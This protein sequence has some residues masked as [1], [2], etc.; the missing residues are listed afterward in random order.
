MDAQGV[1]VEDVPQARHYRW[2]G[3]GTLAYWGPGGGGLFDVES[4]RTRQVAGIDKTTSAVFPDRDDGH[5]WVTTSQGESMTVRRVGLGIG[6]D[7]TPSLTVPGF[8]QSISVTPDEQ[9]FVACRPPASG[10]PG[11]MTS[12]PAGSS[13]RACPGS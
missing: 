8:V 5:A 4:Q 12:L 7:T 9:V 3:N 10:K 6:R 13:A 1:E 2:V 11:S